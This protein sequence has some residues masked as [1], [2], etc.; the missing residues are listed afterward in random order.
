MICHSDYDAAR[1]GTRAAGCVVLFLLGL[2]AAAAVFIIV[3]PLMV[4]E[5]RTFAEALPGYVRSI[6]DVLV[7]WVEQTFNLTLP[8]DFAAA[9]DQFGDDANHRRFPDARHR[10]SASRR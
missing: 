8:T 4:R 9:S 2:L 1:T 5:L 7:P 10:I 3:I 6:R